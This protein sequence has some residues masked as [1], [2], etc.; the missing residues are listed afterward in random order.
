[1][2]ALLPAGKSSAEVPSTSHCQPIDPVVAGLMLAPI[3]G[4]ESALADAFSEAA[5]E[6]ILKAA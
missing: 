5:L 4:P 1:M 6:A 2:G 3:A